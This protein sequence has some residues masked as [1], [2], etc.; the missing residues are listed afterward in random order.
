MDKIG[1][2][3]SR[4]SNRTVPVNPVNFRPC[5]LFDEDPAYLSLANTETERRLA[6]REFVAQELDEGMLETIKSSIINDFILGSES[7]ISQLKDKLALS[8]PRPRGRPSS[9]IKL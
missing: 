9:R 5:K 8:K 6:Y 4:F 2:D 3:S 7:F 1:R